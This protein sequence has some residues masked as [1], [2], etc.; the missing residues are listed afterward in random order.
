MGPEPSVLVLLV[1]AALILPAFVPIETYKAQI[2]AGIEGA[3]GRKARIDGDFKFAV[4]PRVELVAGKVS[5]ANA[6]G[7]AEPSMMSFDRLTVRVGLLPLLSGTIEVDALVLEKPVINLEVA[8]N[9]QANWEFPKAARGGA[10]SVTKGAEGGSSAN[11]PLLGPL[12][13]LKLDDVRLVD[14]RISYLDVAAGVKYQVDGVNLTVSLPSLDSPMRVDGMVVWNKET[15]KLAAKI[16]KP[17]AALDGQSTDVEI[18]LAA[19]PVNFSFTGE[20]RGGRPMA[21]G[22]RVTLDVPSLRRLAAWVASPMAPGGGFGPLKIE[23]TVDARSTRV[24]FTDA[25]VNFDAIAGTGALSIDR[26]GRKPLITGQ[27]K[28]GMLDLNPYLPPERAASNKVTAPSGSTAGPDDWSDDPL[29]LSG[30]KAVDADFLLTV[31]G[32]QIRK[33]KIGRTALK[34]GLKGGAL[35]SD[36]TDMALYEGNG[37]ASLTLTALSAGAAL[38]MSTDL[39]KFKSNPFL[40]DAMDMDRIEGTANAEMRVTAR[41]R[42]QRELI[43]ALNGAGKIAFTDGAIK[44]ANLAAMVRN[45]QSAFL[46]KSAQQTQKTDFSEMGGTFQIRSGVVTNNDLLMLSPL[47]RLA[48]KGTV[49]LP[50]RRID[51]RVEPKVVASTKGQGGQAGAPGLSVPVNIKGPWHD[52]SYSPDLGAILGGVAKQPGKALESLKGLVPDSGIKSGTTAP[53]KPATPLGDLKGLF[54]R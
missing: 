38:E 33:I 27:L 42:T 29:D 4:L 53:S 28:L 32:I 26:R 24:A 20:V 5:L 2:I 44:G 46:D 13:S 14:G 51:Y 31:A 25:K 6:K 50:K 34:V 18:K 48:G 54:G 22:G 45:M 9:G 16:A 7:A 37:T 30:L 19:A 43:S 39:A 36:L 17:N 21:L 3:T 15:L 40:R 12:S 47:L 10:K 35:R 1:A 8:R 23:G 11:G 52:I 49:D 41:G